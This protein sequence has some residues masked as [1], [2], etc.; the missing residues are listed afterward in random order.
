MPPPTVEAKFTLLMLALPIV[1]SSYGDKRNNL[2][3]FFLGVPT[4]SLVSVGKLRCYRFFG[5]A[6]ESRDQAQIRRQNY[7]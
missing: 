7:L 2:D 1:P 5:G 6:D 3:T 4:E